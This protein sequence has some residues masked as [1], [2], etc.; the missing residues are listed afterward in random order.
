MADISK[1]KLPDGITYNIKAN[2]DV[3]NISNAYAPYKTSGNWSIGSDD[4][5]ERIYAYKTGNVVHFSIA[6]HG[7]GNA[8]SAGSNGFIGT[9]SNKTGFPRYLPVQQVTLTGFY[10]S[11][12][13]AAVLDTDGSITVRPFSASCTLSSAS[14][15]YLTGTFITET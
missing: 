8:V 14:R 11:S 13:L 12:M 9:I 3:E 15:A 5:V 4:G 2:T 1:I 6:F 10:S 7:N